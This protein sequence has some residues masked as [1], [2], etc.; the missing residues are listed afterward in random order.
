MLLISDFDN[1]RVHL[2]C[3]IVQD[4]MVGDESILEGNLQRP[5]FNTSR[6][7]GV[8]PGTGRVQSKDEAVRAA[9][10][11]GLGVRIGG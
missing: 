10:E 11:P 2:A 4:G 8:V 6:V 3:A 7:R 1:L 9:L 5:G